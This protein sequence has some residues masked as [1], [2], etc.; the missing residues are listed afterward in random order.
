MSVW[1]QRTSQL[2]RHMQMSSQEGINKDEPH[3]INPHASIFRR[4]KPGDGV[5]LEKCAEEQGGKGER[6]PAEGPEQ[7]APGA[8]PGGGEDRRS[9]SPRA[10]RDKE[11][12]H[13]KSCHGNCEPGEQEGAGGSIEDRARM[14]QSQRRSRHRR[15]R[16]E[17]KEP[18]SALGSRSASQELGLEETSPTEGAQDGDRLGDVAAA[19]ALIQ[20]EQE[21]SEE[22]IRLVPGEGILQ[23]PHLLVLSP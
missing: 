4:K 5:T 6:P 11:P 9:P 14:R 2:R 16:M 23:F 1:E 3:L 18:A 17:G 20:G 19:E 7:T 8:N 15:A 13:Q 12:W 21:A 10:R 22:P